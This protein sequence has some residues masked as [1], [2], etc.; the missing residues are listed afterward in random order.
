MIDENSI[1]ENHI[2]E[3]KIKEYEQV[4]IQF[5]MESGKAKSIDPNLQLILGYIGIHKKLTQ[6]QLKDLTGLSMGTISKKLRDILALKLIRKEKIPKTNKN[7]YI[8][9]PETYGDVA[10]ATLDDITSMNEFLKKK[11][12]ELEKLREKKGGEFLLERIIGL[13]KT[14]ETVKNIWSDIEFIFKQK[15]N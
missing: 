14:F 6:K 4:L 15:E 3:G 8:L 13:T 12:G 11:V 9:A 5:V 2:F 1:V 10:D 7:L